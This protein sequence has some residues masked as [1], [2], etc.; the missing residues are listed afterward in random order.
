[1]TQTTLR[2]PL[3]VSIESRIASTAKD[4][5]LVNAYVET[6]DQEVQEVVK[7]PGTTSF[8]LTPAIPSGT[9]YGLKAFNTKFY[10]GVGG[11]LY[12]YVSGGTSVD[13]GAI[14]NGK[15]S[16]IETSETPY[17][18]FHNGTAGWTLN[19]STGTLATVSDLDFPPNQTPALPL[20]K[21]AVYLDDMVFVMTTSGRIYNSG[22][23]NPTSW[24]ALDYIS[25]TA[26]A[27]GGVALAKHLNFIVAWG[28]FSGEFFYNAGNPTGSPLLPYY[29]LS[30]QA[31]T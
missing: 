5:R 28:D 21:G 16:F 18:F 7:R 23:E 24:D 29:C 8:A 9:S 20:A 11:R 1:M 13:K 19:G 12:E 4:S 15:L 10:A 6:V 31:E 27:D 22:I 25:K 2:F 14:S 17:L 30:L 26:E 3:G